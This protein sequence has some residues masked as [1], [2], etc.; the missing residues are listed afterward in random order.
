MQGQR[1]LCHPQ[2][3]VKIIAGGNAARNI[4]KIDSDTGFFINNENRK[5]GNFTQNNLLLF[6]AGLF[7]DAVKDFLLNIA[8]VIRYG[9][10]AFFNRVFKLDVGTLLPVKKPAV[11]TQKFQNF[12]NRHNIIIRVKHTYVKKFLRN[13]GLDVL[14]GFFLGD[15]E[16]RLGRQCTG[17]E[18][19]I[20]RR[21]KPCTRWYKVR[22]Q[23]RQNRGKTPIR[24]SR[25]VLKPQI[26]NWK[27]AS[28][29]ICGGVIRGRRMTLRELAGATGAA[30]RTAA[31]YA[32]KAG[33][34]SNGKL[35]LLD[36]I[37]A[38]KRPCPAVQ[39]PTLRG[40]CKVSTR[41][42]FFGGGLK[43]TGI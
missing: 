19:E 36:E 34:T 9:N 11:I 13:Y 15:L 41:R 5:I 25:K 29:H 20:A 30:Y 3:G 43:H 17:M 39:K 35:R 42:F 7:K 40:A 1:L 27:C 22:K 21:R 32:R 14:S 2:S 12:P 26:S 31:D 28:W 18:K 33:R 6:Q 10:T 23:A 4:G 24:L 38:M 37:E 16:S 8:V